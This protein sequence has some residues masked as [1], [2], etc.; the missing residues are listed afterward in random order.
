MF[1]AITI[2]LT[3][4]TFVAHGLLGCCWHHEHSHAV[5][6]VVEKAESKSTEKHSHHHGHCGHES[7]NTEAGEQCPNDDD[8][9]GQHGKCSEGRCVLAFTQVRAGL[10]VDVLANWAPLLTAV[11]LPCT[12][13]NLRAGSFVTENGEIEPHFKPRHAWLN[14]WLI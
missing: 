12:L 13:E 11:Q 9:D 3:A 14:V 5:S 8:C 7:S 1:R 6:G 4:A 2:L 10:S